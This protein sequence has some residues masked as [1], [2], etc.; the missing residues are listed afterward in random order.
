MKVYLAL[1]AVFISCSIY[2]F[3]NTSIKEDN[4]NGEGDAPLEQYGSLTHGG[5]AENPNND[6]L[7]IAEI[8]TSYVKYNKGTIDFDTMLEENMTNLESVLNF[9][10]N[11]L[12]GYLFSVGFDLESKHQFYY[13][14]NME[15]TRTVILEVIHQE[16]KNL[17]RKIYDGTYLKLVSAD[18]E[19]PNQLLLYDANN[20]ESKLVIGQ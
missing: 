18:D 3:Y 8:Q 10:F 2:I 1:I 17:V 13:Q 14:S 7:K 11:P 9:P 5:V 20:Q 15:E 4:G 6:T 16:D 19:N 12:K